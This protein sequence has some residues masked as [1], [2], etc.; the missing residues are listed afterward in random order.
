MTICGDR[1]ILHLPDDRSCVQPI[2]VHGNLPWPVIYV[3]GRYHKK[4]L[5]FSC[6]LPRVRRVA[7]AMGEFENQLRWK[8]VYRCDINAV[9]SVRVRANRRFRCCQLVDPSL[10]AFL[11]QM[12]RK[13]LSACEKGICQARC[14][15]RSFCNALPVLRCALVTMKRLGITALLNDKDG[16]FCLIA[17]EV[18]IQ[19]KEQ[20]LS[21]AQYVEIYPADISF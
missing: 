9:P 11:G 4:H 17:T 16:G 6:S 13:V 19:L 3:L 1:Y 14:M 21:S 8:W 18:M 2:G 10:Q 12:R 15:P 20:A 7:D 5:F